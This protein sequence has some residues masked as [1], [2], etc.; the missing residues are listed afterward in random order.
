MGAGT[1]GDLDG[2]VSGHPL[3]ADGR[4]ARR[5]RG[6]LS[7]TEAM[8]DLALEGHLPP[9]AEQ[10]AERAGVSQASLFRY[11]ENLDELRQATVQRYFERYAHLFVIPDIG[12]GPLDGRI[13]RLVDARLAQYEATEPMARLARDRV[14][15]GAFGAGLHQGRT[16]LAQQVAEH[17]AVELQPLAPT[18]RDDL[19]AVISTL[20]SFESWLQLR[21]EHGRSGH[22]ARR[23]W[24][25][26][27]RILF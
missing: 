3:P 20:T 15:V 9:T 19:V 24:V 14:A 21:E 13:E 5:A 10:V 6:R 2:T 27:L 8:I 22:D 26:A 4:R 23:V 16:M 1:S 7:V 12:S 25:D 18:R 11:F 17:F